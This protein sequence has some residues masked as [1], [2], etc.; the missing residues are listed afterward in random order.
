[1]VRLHSEFEWDEQK[2]ESNLRKHGVSFDLAVNVLEDPDGDRFHLDSPDDEHADG[3]DR[4][5][6]IGSVPDDR[7]IVL[8]ISWT[9]RS[10]DVEQV[11]RIIS[12]RRADKKERKRYADEL[13]G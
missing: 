8:V 7:R 4:V 1:M 6:T 5:I 3:E 10:T 12:A 11:T 2:A 9:D 13:G